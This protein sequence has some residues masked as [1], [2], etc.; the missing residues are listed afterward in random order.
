MSAP[1]YFSRYDNLHMSRDEAGVL[2]L[3]MHSDGGPIV[4]N[5]KTTASSSTPSTTSA[6]TAATAPWCLPAPARSGWC[7][8]TRRG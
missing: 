3:R 5:G 2:L 7:G 8:S 6:A 1:E 4:W